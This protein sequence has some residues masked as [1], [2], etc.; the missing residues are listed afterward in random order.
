MQ[1]LKMFYFKSKDVATM[2]LVIHI[3]HICY[4]LCASITTGT[5]EIVNV[6][7][8]AT[9]Q[10]NDFLYHKMVLLYPYGTFTAL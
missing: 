7:Y 1:F 9:N 3:Q 10:M 8:S 2:A 4:F 5:T 6:H